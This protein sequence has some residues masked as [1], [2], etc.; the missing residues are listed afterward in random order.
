MS[1]SPVMRSW[2]VLL[3]IGLSV[4]SAI[5]WAQ[6]R[7]N[8]QAPAARQ[9]TGLG[10]EEA[11]ALIAK[12]EEAQRRLRAGELQ[13]F[14]L[15]AGSM[16][17]SETTKVSPRDAFL[18][19]PFKRVWNIERVQTDNRLWQPHRLAYAPNGPGQLYWDIEVVL[20]SEGEIERVLMIYKPRAP[21]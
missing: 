10:A 5:G 11:T 18:Q 3:L 19:V 7:S 20:G 1:E 12:L 15:L 4:Q 14:E 9:L 17:S 2:Y 21:F 16:A 6:T 8:H 13:T